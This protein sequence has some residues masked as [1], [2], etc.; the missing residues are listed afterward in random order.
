MKKYSWLYLQIKIKTYEEASFR[1]IIIK[2][3]RDPR[4]RSFRE[5]VVAFQKSYRHTRSL[6]PRRRFLKNETRRFSM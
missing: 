2:W 1:Q 3:K 6:E 4:F 5:R